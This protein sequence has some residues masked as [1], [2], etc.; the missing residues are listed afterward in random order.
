MSIKTFKLCLIIF[1]SLGVVRSTEWK[2]NEFNFNEK[3]DDN[4][5]TETK[6]EDKISA[7]NLNFL[8]DSSEEEDITDSKRQME[9][10][11]DPKRQMD[12]IEN[13][14]I[15]HFIENNK[16]LVFDYVRTQKIM[17]L[18]N[19]VVTQLE[20]I[21]NVLIKRNKDL[22]Q[23]TINYINSILLKKFEYALLDHHKKHEDN[24]FFDFHKNINNI[25]DSVKSNEDASFF[26]NQTIVYINQRIYHIYQIKNNNYYTINNHLVSH[27]YQLLID[28]NNF[29]I[30]IPIPSIEN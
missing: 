30:A 25:I 13:N 7:I 2:P 15:S 4:R 11:I 21:I 29:L 3:H 24:N 18:Q 20:N 9:D 8:N 12:N 23:C 1:F 17:D 10:I 14:K 6:S 19:W 26:I 22:I 16:E 5:D 28:P 27:G